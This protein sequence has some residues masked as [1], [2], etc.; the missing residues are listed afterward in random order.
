MKRS[1]AF[2]TEKEIKK[3]RLVKELEGRRLPFL[4]PGD[5]GF[6][7][8]WETRFSSLARRRAVAVPP[9]LH[10][11]VQASLCTLL[12]RGC[13]LRDLVRVRDRDVF[14][15]VSRVLLGRRGHTYCYLHTR[16]FA[17]PWHEE[18]AEATGCCD[19]ELGAACRALGELNR[20][21]RADA[22]RTCGTRG[23]APGDGEAGQ[24][25]DV[26][27]AP[28][29][30]GTEFNVALV[31]YM[32]PAAASYLKEEPYFGMGRMAVSWHHDENL[33][34]GST[35]AVYNYSCEGTDADPG[36]GE[37][38]GAAW[39]VGLKVAWDIDTPGLVLPLQ[40][41]DCY[42][43]LG[44]AVHLQGDLDC[45]AVLFHPAMPVQKNCS[46]CAAE[47]RRWD[48]LNTT[49]Q[50]CVL[51]GASARFS[52]TH[53]VAECSTGTLDYIQ[54]RCQEALKF[55]RSDLDSGTHTLRSLEPS[56]LQH[57]EEIHNEV[58]FQW[59]RQ[60]WFQGRRYEKFCSWW[61]KPMEEL[62]EA[63]RKMEIMTQLA[64]AVAEDAAR[65][66]E[67]RREVAQVLLPFLTE[68]QERRQLW[69]ARF[70]LREVSS[71]LPVRGSA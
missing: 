15:A 35:V 19:E 9:Q 42:Y 7:Q 44:I 71:A 57:C 43:M 52:S 23:V 24:G 46:M 26:Q 16:L 69:R 41:G 40:S 10:R 56:V 65:T 13:L 18:G 14:T 59:L 51:A 48:D 38:D 36:D 68:R 2:E 62:E 1:E 27:G 31:N 54:R 37:L 21:F 8:L 47:D 50:H 49:H 6:Q 64:L 32:D 33:V 53:R 17:V 22:A 4:A 3:Q 34:P 58:E 28:P 55:L 25:R 20:Y 39:R 66:M 61:R 70:P 45:G 11:Q 5:A 67:R 29:S 12:R 60:Y 30:S 63:W